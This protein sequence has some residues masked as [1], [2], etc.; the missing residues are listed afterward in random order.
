MPFDLG[1]SALRAWG[2]T[3]RRRPARMLNLIKSPEDP[4]AVCGLHLE[5][6]TW[7]YLAFGITCYSECL[8]PPNARLSSSSPPGIWTLSQAGQSPCRESSQDRCYLFQGHIIIVVAWWFVYF[9]EH[10]EVHEGRSLACHVNLASSV[11][12]QRWAPR[13]AHALKPWQLVKQKTG[14]S[15]SYPVPGPL[16]YPEP[17]ARPQPWNQG[18]D[19]QHK[20][21]RCKLPPLLKSAKMM[22]SPA[23]WHNGWNTEL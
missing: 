14:C 23:L 3:G 4:S 6:F 13:P 2:E 11:L 16:P 20:E 8:Q 7:S 5:P 19:Q 12:A 1:E 15:P 17:P 21:V 22:R 10:C 18:K 9:L